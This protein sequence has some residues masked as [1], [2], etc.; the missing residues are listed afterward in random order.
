M[1]QKVREKFP[2]R[3]VGTPAGIGHAAVYLLTNPYIIGTVMGST[4]KSRTVVKGWKTSN[5]LWRPFA[6][7]L[8]CGVARCIQ[9]HPLL[10]HRVSDRSCGK[11]VRLSRPKKPSHAALS[12]Q[13][14]TAL[15]EH[16]S[17]L[18]SKYF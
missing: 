12:P 14:P 10:Q 3:R 18:A 15:I 16:T 13:C 9:T 6:A 17:A 8:G 5:P 4:P 11:S 2:M 1:R 7:S